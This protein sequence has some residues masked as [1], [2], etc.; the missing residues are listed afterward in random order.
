MTGI[1][2]QLTS[3]EM[4]MDIKKTILSTSPPANVN[5]NMSTE[6]CHLDTP[7]MDKETTTSKIVEMHDINTNMDH[8]TLENKETLTILSNASPN[9]EMDSDLTE[10]DSIGHKASETSPSLA[11]KYM[12][13][14]DCGLSER[15]EFILQNID[16][17]LKRIYAQSTDIKDDVQEMK[18]E[19]IDLRSSYQ[20]LANNYDQQRQELDNLKTENTQLKRQMRNQELRIVELEQYSRRNNVLF[21]NIQENPTEN[22]SEIVIK[23][24]EK[25]G[26]TVLP[27]TLHA[28][29][30]MGRRQQPNAKQKP[31]VLIA[32][33]AT[34]DFARQVVSEAKRQFKDKTSP[35]DVNR[36]VH[37]REHLCDSRYRLLKLC[38]SMREEGRI[39]SCWTFNHQ[40]YVKKCDDDRWGT[41]MR[42]EDELHHFLKQR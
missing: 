8:T 20:F 30:R 1:K 12:D 32:R 19:I 35:P 4:N 29:H 28:A 41:L 34:A 10:N 24:C 39:T 17:E 25:L 26:V 9:I 23:Q 27:E 15:F 11:Q 7:S 14:K 40:I 6:N 13:T 5:D 37:A 22:A 36:R 18:R 31:R 2:R 42:S 21:Y 3:P 33:F 38:M 16:T